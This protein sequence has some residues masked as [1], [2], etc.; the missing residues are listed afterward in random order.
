[1]QGKN[2]SFPDVRLE[3]PSANFF[4]ATTSLESYQTCLSVSFGGLNYKKFFDE[5]E[6]RIHQEKN[7]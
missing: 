3:K 7:E 6:R 1:L 5:I 4:F 2:R